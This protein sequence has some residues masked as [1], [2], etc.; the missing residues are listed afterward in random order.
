MALCPPPSHITQHAHDHGEPGHIEWGKKTY[1]LPSV[2]LGRLLNF[3]PPVRGAATE[4][5]E[6][7]P[8]TA[9]SMVQAHPRFLEFTRQDF[10][11]IK[12]KL[13]PLVNCYGY[14]FDI[15]YLKFE[16]VGGL[17]ADSI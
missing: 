6:V 11:A 1:A 2:D 12:A 16:M 17:V 10:A 15:L 14:V 7:T 3:E 5:G 13:V 8:I 9:W 4:G